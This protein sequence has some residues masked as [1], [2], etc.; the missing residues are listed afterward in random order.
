MRKLILIILSTL[1]LFTCASVSADDDIM[2]RLISGIGISGNY[3]YIE[4]KVRRYLTI[5]PSDAYSEEAMDD[6]I[7]RIKQFYEREGWIGTEVDVTPEYQDSTGS[8]YLH[9]KIKRGFLLRYRDI[10]VTGNYSLPVSLVSSKINTWK[11][12]KPTR[13]RESVQRIINFYKAH[14]YLLARV[15]VTSEER[16]LEKHRIDV[17]V[18]IEQGPHVKVKFKGNDHLGGRILKEKITLLSEGAIDSFEME[19]SAKAIKERYVLRGFPDAKVEFKRREVS[20]ENIVI[21]FAI[22]EGK[23]ERIR[24]I[25]FTGNRDLSRSSI[26][27]HMGSKGLSLFHPGIYDKDLLNDDLIR[28][29][30]YY[31]SKGFPEPR[32]SQP[33]ISKLYDGTQLVINIPIEEGPNYVLKSIDFTG[34]LH[35]PEKKLLKVIKA[36]ID[37]PLNFAETGI[38]KAN[39]KAFYAD[40]GYPYA[41]VSLDINKDEASNGAT[42]NFNINSGP[43]VRF[44]Q[45][46]ILGD[47]LTSQKAIR[48]AINI[49]EGEPFSYEKVVMSKVGLRRLDAFY[50]TDI[51][52]SGLEEKATL[53]PVTI[54]VEEMRPFDLDFNIGY[55]TDEKLIG[56]VEFLNRNSFGW[57]KRTI[58]RLVGGQR[59]SRGEIGW[60]DPRLAGHDIELSASTWLQYAN[61]GVVDYVQGGGGIGLMRRYHRTTYVFRNDLTRNLPIAGRST[62]A[63]PESLRDNT[64]LNTLLSVTF[65]TR[66]SF[67]DPTRGAYVNGYSNFFNEIRGMHANFVKLGTIG[68]FY[69]S[70][71]EGFTLAN[72]ARFEGIEPFGNNVSV[73]SNQL[74]LLGG[75][76]SVRG[77]ERNSLG[78]VNAQ[79]NPTGGRLRF[80][81]NNE[82]RFRIVGNFKWVVFHDMGFLTNNFSAVTPGQLRHSLGFGLHYITPIGPIKADYGFIL[83]RK[84]GEHVGRFHLTFG[85]I[86]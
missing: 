84:P 3:P 76:D 9:F 59:F 14:G 17:T 16:D 18:N 43:E 22:D 34:E 58:M 6:Q 71:V 2:N 31:R 21:T 50:S 46:T 70:F 69:L 53:L 13:L 80:V 74:L 11:P 55:S 60:I 64:I 28:I 36:K 41:E 72:D 57:G 27:S 33:D 48:K 7:R 82:F 39:L 35:F 83:A 63:D 25:K 77:F 54:K 79:G 1:C 23:P 12:Y 67:A 44:G 51:K 40:H 68:G 20:P 73:P 56:G 85:Y 52:I 24:E 38:E 19:E 81:C 4:N 47:F 29:D 15:K 65:D 26:A 49:R 10:K 42:M 78:P 75:D 5:R 62:A 8:V 37:R 66:N 30:Q 32:V 86:F 61:Q 45:I